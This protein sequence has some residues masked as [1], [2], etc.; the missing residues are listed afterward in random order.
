MMAHVRPEK[1]SRWRALFAAYT[2]K[3]PAYLRA[4]FLDHKK[5]SLGKKMKSVAK[6]TAS[7][8]LARMLAV[9][10][11]LVIAGFIFYSH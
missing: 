4:K 2:A 11:M 3:S 1:Y 5:P 8:T 10:A 6:G 7:E 9:T